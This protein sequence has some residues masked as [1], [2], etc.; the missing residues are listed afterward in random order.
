MW[1][2]VHSSL[3]EDQQ[4]QPALRDR[5]CI[6]QTYSY[7]ICLPGPALPHAPC[8][9]S[10]AIHGR[11]GVETFLDHLQRHVT[12]L[13]AHAP[14][15]ST[16]C[17]GESEKAKWNRISRINSPTCFSPMT[18]LLN[19]TLYLWLKE[20]PAARRGFWHFQGPIVRGSFSSNL[21]H[22]CC[23]TRAFP[24]SYLWS[25]QVRKSLF[26]D[27]NDTVGALARLKNNF[28]QTELCNKSFF[29]FIL[30]CWIRLVAPDKVSCKMMTKT[31]KGAFK[32][33]I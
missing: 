6:L 1:D 21:Q 3:S 20:S 32:S 28:L 31:G 15:C 8:G 13:S 17:Q 24:P 27:T 23:W 30:K 19:S 2:L 29:A 18:V 25:A 10:P 33:N 16:P 12:T 11:A 22:H 14:R 26:E 9:P 4:R 7:T 5:S